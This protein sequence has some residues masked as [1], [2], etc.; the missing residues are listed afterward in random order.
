M[1]IIITQDYDE[2][3]LR[4][5][6]EILHTIDTKPNSV[7][8]LATGSTVKGTYQRVID[9]YTNNRVSFQ[10]AYSFN[11]DEYVGL[12]QDHVQSYHHF[13]ENL[14]FNHINLP[15]EHQYIPN[16]NAADL[17]HE[18]HRYEKR[19]EDLGGVD[20]QLLG[21]GMNGHIGF[22]E[23]GTPFDSNTHMV[24]LD[25]STRKANSRFFQNISDVPTHAITAG[26]ATIMKSKKLVLLVSGENKAEI[27][28]E[29]LLSKVTESIPATALKQHPNVTI[30]ADEQAA[31][32]YQETLVNS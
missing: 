10:N 16:G 4:V 6:E 22:N 7:L 1:E 25:A 18:I 31:R 17:N 21:I 26:I 8:G 13:M 2:M 19:L 29:F 24:E 3:S 11:L 30:V 20:L 28:K 12:P 23:P 32:F 27:F 15:K 9:A 14:L 5:T